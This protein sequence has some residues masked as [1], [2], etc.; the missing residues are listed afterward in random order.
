MSLGSRDSDYER[1][2]AGRIKTLFP[3][4]AEQEKPKIDS[5][6]TMAYSRE[7]PAKLIR[8]TLEK[9]RPHVNSAKAFRT[10]L[11]TL[12]ADGN[13]FH[14]YHQAPPEAVAR[15]PAFYRPED[16]DQLAVETLAHDVGIPI[17]KVAREGGHPVW[18]QHANEVR[19]LL[20]CPAF[21]RRP[22]TQALLR[23]SFNRTHLDHY[24]SRPSN[25]RVLRELQALGVSRATW[26]LE[27]FPK[28]Y[29]DRLG[30][31]KHLNEEASV[32]AHRTFYGQLASIL[33]GRKNQLIDKN[34]VAKSLRAHT[35]IP[36]RDLHA[37]MDFVIEGEKAAAG[38]KRLEQLGEHA[39][40]EEEMNRVLL[41]II[42]K[43]QRKM[44][45]DERIVETGEREREIETQLVA[46]QRT[47]APFDPTV[48]LS[49]LASAPKISPV[50]YEIGKSNKDP[51]HFLTGGNDSGVCD[52]TTE[53]KA[54][55]RPLL[56]HK[57]G[58]QEAEI[59]RR[60]KRGRKRIGQM[61]MYAAT[62]QEG[63]PILLI[64]SIDLEAEQRKNLSVYRH[65][66]EYAHDL[67]QAAGFSRVLLGRH[68]D[69]H[70]L[71]Y[72]EHP[73][74]EGI[75][76]EKRE[77]VRLID[78]DPEHERFSDFFDDRRIHEQQ[79]TIRAYEVRLPRR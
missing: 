34:E 32:Q 16:V 10:L 40:R 21:L 11:T 3:E 19:R 8:S 42:G 77:H 27:R 9:L 25:E 53:P 79:G 56:A 38:A 78:H 43:M 39:L 52:A 71:P 70:L 60:S 31:I 62:D 76:H 26:L 13:L 69:N 46:L 17:E 35:E 45:G 24:D 33:R 63:K 23:H 15:H 51:I 54:E 14:L 67:G 12:A 1:I 50:K 49:N 22:A 6:I 37:A 58:Y 66:L 61:R 36:F 30:E 75:L 73:I 4:Y 20:A 44:Q 48:S 55:F 64:N 18:L 59:F 65:C 7:I 28:Q 47:V 72:K 41:A 2:V 74:F 57:Y 5:L 68:A 29:T